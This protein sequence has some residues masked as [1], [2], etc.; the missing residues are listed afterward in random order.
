MKI[1]FPRDI[2]DFWDPPGKGLAIA[3][4]RRRVADRIG[5]NVA[6]LAILTLPEQHQSLVRGSC[7]RRSVWTMTSLLNA[8]TS[9]ELVPTVC[10]VAPTTE[11][12]MRECS[13]R[14]GLTVPPEGR[15]RKPDPCTQESVPAH[16][17]KPAKGGLLN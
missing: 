11:F 10:Q 17:S 9:G 8:H 5:L 13:H 15:G 7:E 12:H 2:Y 4:T 1:F 14:G 3:W 6:I 16:L